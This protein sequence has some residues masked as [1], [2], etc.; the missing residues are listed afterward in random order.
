MGWSYCGKD[1]EGRDIGYSISATCDH[2]GCTAQ[3]DRGLS[4][5]CGSMHG[6]TDYGCDKY[7]CHEHLMTVGSEHEGQ[8]CLECHKQLKEGE[9]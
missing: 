2:P 4:Y 3:I 6:N 5:A 1:S 7:F 9:G 8:L